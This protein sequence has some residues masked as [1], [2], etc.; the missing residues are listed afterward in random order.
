MK[1][2]ARAC[3]TDKYIFDLKRHAFDLGLGISGTGVGNN[4]TTADKAARALDVQRIK[5]W[6]EVAGKLGA[7]VLRVFADTQMRD[8]T[9]QTVSK[10]AT[11]DQVEEWIADNIR[12]CADYAGKFGVIIGVQNHGDF[13]RTADDLI[14]LINRINSPWCG[15]IVDTGYFKAPDPYAE[16]AKAAP[17]AVN[18]QVK[19]SP[20]RRRK[21]GGGANRP[22]A[23]A[24]NRPRVR[25]S[26]L[27]AHRDIV[28]ARRRR[29]RSLQGRA[30]ISGAT[31]GSH[32]RNG[33]NC[34]AMPGKNH[35]N[36][37]AALKVTTL[38]ALSLPL[39]GVT[40][41]RRRKPILPIKRETSRAPALKLGVASYSLAKLPVEDVIKVL[42]QLEI[43]AV[44]LYKTHAPWA[45]GTPDECKA[46]VQKFSDAGIA[47]TS[48]G[49]IEL[50]NDEAVVRK[51]LDN[52]RAAGLKTFC[53][54]VKQTDSLPLMD[55]LVKEYDLKV[56]IHNH[57]PTELLATG[58]DVWKA[59]QPFDKRIGLCLD[60]GHGFRA[61]ENP[62]ET[63][64]QCHERIYEVHL[65][66]TAVTG[67]GMKD[68]QPVSSVTGCWISGP[69]S[70]RC[71]RSNIPSRP[72]SNMRRKEDDRLPGLAESVGYVRGLLASIAA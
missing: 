33:V 8:E 32:C 47:V 40:L 30:R 2:M 12:E 39:I 68:P 64:R 28:P 27:F 4:F 55:T 23:I 51:A 59:V 42:K 35:L 26:R 5:N 53:G 14:H 9:W 69:S 34:A 50:P 17:Y 56:A 61:G 36:R 41:S 62:A 31:S 37:R 63:I 18:W 49:M 72:S 10:G 43:T 67:G 1:R 38:S 15:A 21:R 60:V 19:Q 70:P 11:R 58:M 3:P 66:D 57:G 16:M 48:T 7:P 22:Q 29:L 6:A 54:W 20:R 45:D 71:S 65:R 13:L 46:V 52:V 25:L 44:S 24:Q